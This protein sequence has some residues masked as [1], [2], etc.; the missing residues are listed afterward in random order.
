[1]GDILFLDNQHNRHDLSGGL[2]GDKFSDIIKLCFSRA[3]AFSLIQR[4][5]LPTYPS[6]V[7]DRLSPH[8]I[9]R[10]RVT[11][12]FA[13]TGGE[14][15]EILYKANPQTMEIILCC[16]DD[17]FLQNRK[18]ISKKKHE[19]I[20]KTFL[21]PSFL[22]D[23]CFFH[24]KKMFFGTLSHEYI[25]AAKPTDEVFEKSLYELASWKKLSEDCFGM[26]KIRIG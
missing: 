16:F 12:W 24:K 9:A 26:G 6:F 5:T 19:Q 3:D 18:K 25:C 8:V 23:L 13:W 20:G 4:N 7:E 1:M 14:Y 21:Y 22:E 15:D 17:I 11:Q 10:C 2:S